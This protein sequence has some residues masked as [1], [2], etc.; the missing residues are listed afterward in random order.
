M[1]QKSLLEERDTAEFLERMTGPVTLKYM[2]L[3]AM[4]AKAG[5]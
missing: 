5:V 4:G 1:L 3:E 2:E